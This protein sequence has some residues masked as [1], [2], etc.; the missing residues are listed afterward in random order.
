MLGQYPLQEL[1]PYTLKFAAPLPGKIIEVELT[2][3]Q[4]I[5]VWRSDDLQQYFCHGLTFGGKDAP[6]GPLSPFTGRPVET[7]LHGYYA[8]VPEDQAQAGDILVWRAPAP[9]S[10][11]HSAVLTH[12]V[13]TPG[14]RYL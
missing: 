5:H 2:N 7:L 11:P 10:T 8:A 9:D 13:I 14:K 6:G 1:G 12:P 4:K 3:G